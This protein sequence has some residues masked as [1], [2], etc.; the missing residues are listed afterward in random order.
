MAEAE[1]LYWWRDKE[2][3]ELV[4]IIEKNDKWIV[5]SLQVVT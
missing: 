2:F 1:V 5:T 3:N 4:A